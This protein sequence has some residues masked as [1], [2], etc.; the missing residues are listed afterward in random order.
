MGGWNRNRL[1]S[2]AAY[3]R[4]CQTQPA[5]PRLLWEVCALPGHK[6]WSLGIKGT[7]SCF[8]AVPRLC[9]L[10]PTASLWWLGRGK[11]SGFECEWEIP[12]QYLES[13]AS[14]VGFCLLCPRKK[15]SLWQGSRP[16]DE[17]FPAWLSLWPG[18]ESP[19]DGC[20]G[21]GT[22]VSTQSPVLKGSKYL[23]ACGHC[24]KFLPSKMQIL[25][26]FV[27]TSVKNDL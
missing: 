7:F 26:A 22:A 3:W 21:C 1:F 11:H 8:A 9:M 25:V 10:T 15:K 14:A 18:S 6:R 13:L 27:K 2:L 19:R 23:N 16:R 24:N 20:R 12:Y 4:C 5:L 17:P